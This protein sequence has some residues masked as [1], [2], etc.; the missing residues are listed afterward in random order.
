MITTDPY[1]DA[2]GKGWMITM[3]VGLYDDN[4]VFYGVVAADIT[5]E[6]IQSNILQIAFLHSG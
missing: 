1:V 2:F 4:N 5:L 3:A 6:T